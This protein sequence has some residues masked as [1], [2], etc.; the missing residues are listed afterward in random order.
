MRHRAWHAADV[1]DRRA[2]LPLSLPGHATHTSLDLVRR[3]PHALAQPSSS[4]DATAARRCDSLSAEAVAR[5][6]SA[7]SGLLPSLSPIKSRSPASPGQKQTGLESMRAKLH[8]D[9]S[10]RLL[11]EASAQESVRSPSKTRVLSP[12]AQGSWVQSAYAPDVGMGERRFTKKVV[13]SMCICSKTQCTHWSLARAPHPKR[14]SLSAFCLT[15][16]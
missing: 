12:V 4:R 14:T 13:G 10:P 6:K 5:K 9:S 15:D 8:G 1:E 11:R 2:S 16:G 7:P 3:S